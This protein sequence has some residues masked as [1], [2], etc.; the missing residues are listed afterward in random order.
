MGPRLREDN[1]VEGEDHPHP[2]SSRG[3]ALTFPLQGGREK[4]G[5]DPRIREDNGGELGNAGLWQ[6]RTYLRGSHLK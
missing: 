3:Q 4:E 6:R 5:M 1:G 2:P